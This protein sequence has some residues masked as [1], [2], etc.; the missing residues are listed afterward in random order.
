M[1]V[2]DTTRE[3]MTT[4]QDNSGTI[5]WMSPERFKSEHRRAPA[6]DVYAF[7]CICYMVQHILGRIFE[8]A[9]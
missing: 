3:H 4:T 1:L 9:N 2:N 7:A 5:A 8:Y 6:D